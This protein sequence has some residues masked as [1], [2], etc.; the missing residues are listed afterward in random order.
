MAPYP[1]QPQDRLVA[2]CED[3]PGD[4]TSRDQWILPCVGQPR[5]RTLLVAANVLEANG[6]LDIARVGV[7]GLGLVGVSAGAGGG[8]PVVGR[9]G[10][11][12]AC[13]LSGTFGLLGLGAGL[14]LGLGR[15]CRLAGTLERCL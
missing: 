12:L 13:A 1:G 9:L 7:V 8:R 4:R 2:A 10:G 6:G 3:T 14:P 11:I 15:E 5:C